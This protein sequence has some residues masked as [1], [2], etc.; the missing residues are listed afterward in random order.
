MPFAEHLDNRAAVAPRQRSGDR[1][2]P[3]PDPHSAPAGLFQP[4]RPFDARMLPVSGGHRIYVEQCGTPE[5]TPVLVLHG[6]PGGGIHPTLRRFF[7]PGSFHVVLFDQRG[8]GRSQPH[9]S[10]RNNTTWDLIDDIETI[11]TGLGIDRWI[12]FGGS[13][14]ATLGLLYAQRH[15]GRVRH[16]VLRGPF[17]STQR[18]LDWFYGGGAARFFPERWQRFIGVLPEAERDDVISGFHRGLFGPD[19]RIRKRYAQAWALWENALASVKATEIAGPVSDAYAIAIARLENHY[20]THGG[21][22]DE[23]GQILR[24]MAAIRQL[25]GTIVQGRYDMICPPD[26]AFALHAAWPASTLSLVPNA[27]HS[28]TEPG[29]A[30]RLLEVMHTFV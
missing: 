29:I 3:D 22:L 10:V 8:C 24:D 2:R 27:G 6:G 30:A 9:A 20:F 26:S 15:P 13:W 4:Q 12:V 19:A 18:E 1:S 17:L 28:V 11:R 21:F 16:L 23:D 25:P 7:D 5:A 14:G